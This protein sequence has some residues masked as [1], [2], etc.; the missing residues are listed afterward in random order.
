MKISG[1][2]RAAIIDRQTVFLIIICYFYVDNFFNCVRIYIFADQNLKEM[3]GLYSIPVN[4][5]KEGHHSFHFEINNKFFDL[6]EESEIKEGNL[7]AVVEAEKRP[8]HI[9]LDIVIT[10]S[11]RICCD[12]CLG[13]FDFLISSR[14]RLVI[15]FGA[16]HEESDPEIITVPRDENDFDLKQYIYEFI[17]L[18]LPIKRI[19]PDDSSGNSTCDPL[20]LEKLKEHIVEEESIEDPRWEELKKLI[21]GN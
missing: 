21:N 5:A 19:H 7:V 1:N 11:V 15:K 17:H 10:G 13:M 14:N 9:E 16:L 4:G 6:F 2:R 12:R 20:M 18:A 8:S 3:S